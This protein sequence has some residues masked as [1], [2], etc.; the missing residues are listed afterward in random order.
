MNAFQR[1]ADVQIQ[2][3]IREGFGLVVAE[4]L[5]KETP[6]VGG[7]TGGITLQIEDGVSGYLVSTVDEAAGRVV[8]LCERPELAEAMGRAGRERVR[9]RFLTT[10]LLEDWLG[11]L[12]EVVA[13]GRGFA[14]H[15]GG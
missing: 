12:R 15:A 8:D 7:L 2:K 3:S 14:A 6:V 1:V 9:Q 5:W 10:R 11:L 13:G 4:A